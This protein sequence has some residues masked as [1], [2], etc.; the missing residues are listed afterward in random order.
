MDSLLVF[1]GTVPR[2]SNHAR[3]ILPTLQLPLDP[4]IVH[5]GEKAGQ[6]TASMSLK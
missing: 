1:S 3:G 5:L 2:A 4:F 6:E